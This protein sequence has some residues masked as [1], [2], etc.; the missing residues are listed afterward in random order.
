[1]PHQKKRLA[2]YLFLIYLVQTITGIYINIKPIIIG[3][4]YRNAIAN[5]NS[6]RIAENENV[7][8]LHNYNLNNKPRLF[9]LVIYMLL[10]PPNKHVYRGTHKQV[11]SIFG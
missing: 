7:R 5:T 8:S 2:S 9:L 4:T 10:L 11:Y 6:W 1:M 3:F